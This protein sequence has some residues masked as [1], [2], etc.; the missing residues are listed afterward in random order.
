MATALS[1]QRSMPCYAGLRPSVALQRNK[2]APA[3]ALSSARASRVRRQGRRT[4]VTITAGLKII[5]VS[6]EVAPWSKTGGLGD[7]LGALPIALA[8][9]GHHVMTVAPRY[10]HYLD[11]PDSEVRTIV[12]WHHSAP[13][14]T[15][16]ADPNHEEVRFFQTFDNGVDRVFVDH[17]CFSARIL[18]SPGNPMGKT[19]NKIYV[20]YDGKEYEDN[21][22]RFSL[23]C[24]AALAAAIKIPHGGRGGET[25]GEDVVFVANDW[26]TAPLPVMIK[27]IQH[28]MGHFKH[29]PVAFCIHNIAYQGR[30]DTDKY[31]RLNMPQS[32][33]PS[34]EFKPAAGVCATHCRCAYLACWSVT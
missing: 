10:D 6:M 31:E 15:M 33:F 17:P 13:S 27:H 32:A 24:Q 9:R 7:V 12:K 1:A 2:H 19:G 18:P 23:I 28:Q 26:H 16:P 3:P 22:L 29:A 34:F 20:G 30:Y 11:V 5:F 21:D 8:Q 14:V 4:P 25:Y